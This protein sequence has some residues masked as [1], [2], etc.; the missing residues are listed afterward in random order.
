MNNNEFLIRSLPKLKNLKYRNKNNV[1]FLPFAFN[2]YD[3]IKSLSI[4]SLNKTKDNI[5]SSASTKLYPLKLTISKNK[6]HSII[7]SYDRK[8]FH[9]IK[10]E[11]FKELFSNYNKLKK[12]S[13]N[14]KNKN[15]NNAIKKVNHAVNTNN[16]FSSQNKLKLNY[17]P[18]TNNKLFFKFINI[19][20]INQICYS[21]RENKSPIYNKALRE[22]FTD[23]IKR[24]KYAYIYLSDNAESIKFLRRTNYNPLDV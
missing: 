17:R 20:D 4:N 19:D 24:D 7:N 10:N 18:I 12:L 15:N 5:K 16:M 1:C 22:C 6:N 13:F 21:S 23:R 14:F 9:N 11:K 2:K 3:E 8:K